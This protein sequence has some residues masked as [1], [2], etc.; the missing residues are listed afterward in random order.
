LTPRVSVVT[1][2]R[3]RHDLLSGALASALGQRGVELEIIV[4]DDGSDPP[5]ADVLVS[6]P[7]LQVVRHE[8]SVGVS[9]A[10]NTGIEHARAD[11]IA[12]LDDDDLWAPDKLRSQLTA[13]EA[14]GAAWAYG[15]DVTVDEDL[16]VIS[17]GPPPAPEAVVA[18]LET[19]NSVPAG[20]SN[21]IVR[22]DA[23]GDAGPFDPSLKTS[24]DWDMW[25]RLTRCCGPPASVPRPLV[26]CRMHAFNVLPDLQAI[27]EEPDLLAARYGL[28]LERA[29]PLRRA[30]WACLRPG[31]RVDAVRYYWRAVILGDIPSVGRAVAAL[32][33]PAARRSAPHEIRQQPIDAWARAAQAWLGAVRSTPAG[34]EE[35][36]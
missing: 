6:D 32:V 16:R 18:G 30:A 31:R 33:H 7:R 14:A 1:P 34:A 21:V 15:G 29:A 26:A 5:V 22:A 27:V 8:T 10:R 2:T 20:A 25:I 3:D 35:G 23:L 13:A 17:G 9:A 11:W 12:F 19:Y 36:N 28:T 24:E 4:V